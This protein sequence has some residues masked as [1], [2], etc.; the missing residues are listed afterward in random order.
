AFKADGEAVPPEITALI[1]VQAALGLHAAHSLV[2]AD[3]RPLPLVHRDVS[4]Q[5]V[6]LSFDGR[7]YVA[8]FGIAKLANA[9]PTTGGVLKGKFAY[10]SPEQARA[11]KLDARSDVFSLGVVLHEALTGE[12]LFA[13]DSPLE[14]LRR[15]AHAPVESPRDARPGVPKWFSDFVMKCL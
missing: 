14:T 15:I 5:N 1:G 7:V 9:D 12:R 2:A 8:D 4:P 13:S 10:M 11:E 3:G 6:L